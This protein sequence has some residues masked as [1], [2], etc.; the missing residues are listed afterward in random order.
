MG[1]TM[2]DGNCIL[3]KGC[4]APGP[5]DDAGYCLHAT[6]IDR[7]FK[8][9]EVSDTDFREQ[10]SK[11]FYH[12]VWGNDLAPE[13]ADEAIEHELDILVAKWQPAP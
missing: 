7:P 2:V 13:L 9:V 11:L 6:I 10:L 5:C 4:S 1:E 12:R 3:G 8:C